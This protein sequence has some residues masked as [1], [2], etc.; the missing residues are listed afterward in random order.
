MRLLAWSAG[1]RVDDGCAAAAVTASGGR[2]L[3]F[4]GIRKGCAAGWLTAKHHSD[5][6]LSVRVTAEIRN[7]LVTL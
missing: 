2:Q 3:Q 7:Q 6:S 5:G 4:G 1:S